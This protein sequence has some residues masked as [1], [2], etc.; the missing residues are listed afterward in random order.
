MNLE[1]CNIVKSYDNREVLKNLCLN[2][3]APVIGVLGPSGCGKSSLIK[4]L[5]GIDKPNK[6]DIYINNTRIPFSQENALLEY[7]KKIGVV[8]QSWNLFPHMTAIEN[9]A[10]PLIKVHKMD[11][12]KAF[13]VSTHL[14]KR[15]ALFEHMHKK[16][17]ALSGG[18]N[19]RVAILRSLAH[20]PEI[21]LLDE[22][23][24]ALDPFMTAEILDL[25]VELKQNGTSFLLISHH[26]T[27]LQN[28]SDHVLFISEGKILESLPKD[29]FFNHVNNKEVRKYL[30]KVMKY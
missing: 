5:A 29:E 15:F 1:M 18:Q 16:P 4:I 11:S 7:R 19:Q 17:H 28:I 2:I 25:L 10:F 26:I 13:D 3:K 27:F 8:F 21:I 9:I 6:G 22:P 23:T 12:Q 20:S 30:E 24:S 14:L